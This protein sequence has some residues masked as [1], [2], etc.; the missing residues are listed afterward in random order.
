[1]ITNVA[2]PL[3]HDIRRRTDNYKFDRDGMAEYLF[4][5]SLDDG[6]D[7]ETGSSSEWKG[8][9]ARFGKRILVEQPGG[10]VY[11]SRYPTEEEA[12]ARFREIDLEYEL[13]DDGGRYMPSYVE[14]D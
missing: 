1:M 6:A 8:Y 13:E 9:F 11:V 2:G 10:G 5:L 14:G 4:N 7:E 3:E 12:K